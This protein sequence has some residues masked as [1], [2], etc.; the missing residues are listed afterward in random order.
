[1]RLINDLDPDDGPIVIS[2][3]TGGVG[4]LEVSIPGKLG[5]HVVAVIGKETEIDF[6][7]NLE[8]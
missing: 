2:V 4:S 6:L 8:I 5:Y 1:M 3:A 7:V